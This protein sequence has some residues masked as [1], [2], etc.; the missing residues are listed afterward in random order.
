MSKQL[1]EKFIKGECT[2][3]EA[4]QVQQ[5][6]D[7]HPEALDDYLQGVWEEPVSAPMPQAMQQAILNEAASW[8]GYQ[9]TTPSKTLTHRWLYWSAAAAIMIGIAGWWLFAPQPSSSAKQPLPHPLAIAINASKMERYVLPDQ[10]VVWLKANA[11]LQVDTQA[12]NKPNRTVALL[13][14]EAFFEVQKDAAHPF[15]V[16]NGPVQTKV[17]G[18]SFSVHSDAAGGTVCVTVATGKVAVMHGEKVLNVLLPGKQIRVQ[19]KTGEYAESTVPVWM[20]SLWK[21]HSL[22]LTNAPFS[23]LQLAMENLYGIQ[24]QTSSKAVK[25]QHYNIRLN[26]ATPVQEIIEVLALLNH[27]QYKRM[28]D[29]TWSV[30]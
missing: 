30:Y 26:R 3:E 6:L 24:L 28:N 21:E 16:K 19:A 14:G 27:H 20:A 12:Y 23:D 25:A 17:L 5:W 2:V 10:S 9:Q 15:I 18:T 22:Q 4:E 13:A 11:R 7:Q 1:L 29:T 8:P